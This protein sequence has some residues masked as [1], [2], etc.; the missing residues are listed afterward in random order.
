MRDK[1]SEDREISRP[2]A[3]TRQS[4]LPVEWLDLGIR[5]SFWFAT[6]LFRQWV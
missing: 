6:N 5:H 4:H 2:G 1:G 3:M